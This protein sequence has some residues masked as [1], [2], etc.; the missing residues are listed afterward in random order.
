MGLKPSFPTGA[1]RYERLMALEIDCTDG[2]T[3]TGQRCFHCMSFVLCYTDS[4]SQHINILDAK[5]SSNLL[6]R[7]YDRFFV[8]PFAR[9]LISHPACLLDGSGSVSGDALA[10]LCL[11]SHASEQ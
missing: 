3:T 9:S 4:R 7:L 5:E 6:I 10:C 2:V 11:S 1:N 8:L